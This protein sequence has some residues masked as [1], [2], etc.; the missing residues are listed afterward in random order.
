[1]IKLFRNIRK[2]LL[3]EG[4]TTKYFK[5]AIG[6]IMLVVIGILIAL[7]INNW[8]EN[9]KLEKETYKVL[10]QMQDEFSRNQTE[11]Q[12]KL[13]QHKFVKASI[14]E[15]SSLVSPNP[16]E[17]EKN[18]LDSIMFSMIYVPEFNAST[19]ISSSEKLVLVDDELKKYIADWKLNYDYY[20]YSIKLTYDNQ[21]QRSSFMIENY[22]SK[23]FKNTLIELNKS[24]FD[25][26]RQKILSSPIFENYVNIRSLNTGFLVKRATAL[27]EIQNKILQNIDA[28]LSNH[29]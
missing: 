15:L 26:D 6:E 16:K 27:Y 3:T 2:N 11:L 12:I 22:Q 18:K 13:E 4:K 17:I 14:D 28:K 10:L 5:Y 7:Q 21:T 1:M 25:S 23:N 8:N 9:N 19:A 20:K 29:D 24:A